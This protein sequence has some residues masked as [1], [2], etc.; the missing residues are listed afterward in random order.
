MHTQLVVWVLVM[1]YSE[2]PGAIFTI[3]S[4]MTSFYARMCLLGALKTKFYILTLFPKKNPNFLLIFDGT[5]KIMRQ[6]GLNNGDA[7]L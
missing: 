2:G 4:Q 7:Y 3:N 6:K 5:W 1:M